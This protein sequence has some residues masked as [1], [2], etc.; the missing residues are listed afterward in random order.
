M[1]LESRGFPKPYDYADVPAG[2]K[3]VVWRMGGWGDYVAFINKISVDWFAGTHWEWTVDGKLVDRIERTIS[4]SEPD[5]YDPHIVA[6]R[7]V[8]W[9][10]FNESSEARKV[11]VLCDGVLVRRVS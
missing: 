5:E 9:T 11:G 8:R 3:A 6:K 10:F 4:I 2:Q 1:P 7:W